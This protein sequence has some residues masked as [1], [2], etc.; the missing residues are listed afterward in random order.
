M[1]TLS[2][3]KAAFGTRCASPFA[4]K[5]ETLLRLAGVAYTRRDVNPMTG[6]RKKVPYLLTPD[7]EVITDSWNIQRHLEHHEGLV[8]APLPL[9]VPLRRTIEEHLYFAQMHMRWTH[10]PAAVHRAFFGELPWPV[11]WLV[12]T[13]VRRQVRSA[14]WGQ[15]MGRRPE[16]EILD[17]VALDL[18]AIEAALGDGPLLGG[19]R[20]SSVDVSLH[21]LL[22]QL[23]PCTLDDALVRAVRARPRLV[24]LHR[25]M[26]AL[27]YDDDPTRPEELPCSTPS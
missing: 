12:F 24:A 10:H 9:E 23:V 13:L 20:P 27:C 7:G 21:G 18:D 3:A 14:L 2:S 11:S 17:L 8:L 26:T 22:E 5:A 1:Y 19:D 6:P 16:R 15:G 4:T 25:H